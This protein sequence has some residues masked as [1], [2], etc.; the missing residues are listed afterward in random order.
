[1]SA[2]SF[3]A[4]GRENGRAHALLVPAD[5][6]AD[7]AGAPE[8]WLEDAVTAAVDAGLDGPDDP[9][10]DEYVAG[11]RDAAIDTIRTRLLEVK[12]AAHNDL[13]GR[14]ELVLVRIAEHLEALQSAALRDA[15]SV[16]KDGHGGKLPELAELEARLR[17][18]VETFR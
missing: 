11:Y 17:A 1:M 7:Y 18:L 9:G 2:T 13:A 5:E 8:A 16:V 15:R 6:L 12:V 10:A 3:A 4:L 14:A